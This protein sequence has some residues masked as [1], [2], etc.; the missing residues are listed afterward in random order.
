MSRQCTP[1]PMNRGP[2][3]ET[4]PS[5]TGSYPPMGKS[6]IPSLY[7][8]LC[9]AYRRPWS[10]ITMEHKVKPSGEGSNLL[11]LTDCLFTPPKTMEEAK[12]NR[13]N[14]IHENPT[15][16]KVPIFVKNGKKERGL[17]GTGCEN[18]GC[19]YIEGSSSARHSQDQVDGCS[20]HEEKSQRTVFK[21]CGRVSICSIP[22]TCILIASATSVF[23][24][25]TAQW[26]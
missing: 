14:L 12:T 26:R 21:R 15:M 2:S 7:Q 5:R 22:T 19:T 10:D 3:A 25:S 1:R 20:E 8:A 4:V 9:P 18:P 11:E 24:L 16:C 6:Q 17:S 23:K 13:I